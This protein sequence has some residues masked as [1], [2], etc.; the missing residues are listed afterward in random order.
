MKEMIDVRV[1]DPLILGQMGSLGRDIGYGVRKISLDR[2]DPKF[3][4]LCRILAQH[5]SETGDKAYHSAQIVRRYSVKELE[6][7]EAY[8]LIVTKVF[9]PAGEEMGTQYDYSNICQLCGAGRIQKSDL[10]LDLQQVPQKVDI[11]RTIADELVVSEKLTNILRHNNIIGCELK[12]V[13]PFNLSDVDKHS[14]WEQLMITE[15]AGPAVAPT[16][17]GIDPIDLDVEGKYKC[18]KNHVAGLNLISELY[19]DRHNLNAKDI[20]ITANMIGHRQGLLVPFPLIIISK[21][22]YY[23]FQKSNIRGYTVEVVHLV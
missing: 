19:I 18:P 20:S 14:G 22:L 5:Q 2:K 11:S 16:L 8:R 3:K 12:T 15:N 17:F 21:R 23:E 10:F 1:S 9:E 13:R 6:Q 7:A 4:E